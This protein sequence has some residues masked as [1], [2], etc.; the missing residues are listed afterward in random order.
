MFLTYSLNFDLCR[1][2]SLQKAYPIQT[3][4]QCIQAPTINQY[5][6]DQ[7]HQSVKSLMDL[8]VFNE[9]AKYAPSPYKQVDIMKR[10]DDLYAKTAD[11]NISAFDYYSNLSQIFLDLKDPHTM[12]YKPKF[13]SHFS[14]I[15]PFQ[16]VYEKNQWFAHYFHND[17]QFYQNQILY[18]DLFGSLNLNQLDRITKIN[19][20][21]PLDFLTSFADLNS[22]SSKTSHSRLNFEL[23]GNLYQ[24]RLDLYNI[25]QT[26]KLCIEFLSGTKL[27]F[28]FL[29]K[30]EIVVKNS[31]EAVK[32]FNMEIRTEQDGEK[33]DSAE[34][35]LVKDY[36]TAQQ[37]TEDPDFKLII[38]SNG[39][40]KMYNYGNRT[41]LAVN[42][43]NPPNYMN[44]LKDLLKLMQ[45]LKQTEINRLYISVMSNPGGVI[46]LGHVLFSGLFS[47]S[48]PFYGRYSIRKTPIA[49]LLAKARA[50][51]FNHHRSKYITGEQIAD[52]YNTT[53]EQNYTDYYSF[54][55]DNSADVL[56]I[57][58]QIY[59]TRL[60]L[61]PNKVVLFTD[62]KCASTC[63]CFSK[64]ILELDLAYS[65]FVG[66]SRSNDQFDVSS[67]AGGQVQ[68][69]NGFE[70]TVKSLNKSLLTEKEYQ[71]LKAIFI[72]HGGL[73]RFAMQQ[74]YSYDITKPVKTLEYT[75]VET[76]KQIKIYPEV[77]NWQSSVTFRKIIDQI[78]LNFSENQWYGE[79][80]KR[81]NHQ[82]YRT[83]ENGCE[84]FGCEFGFYQ[85]ETGHCI[86]RKDQYLSEA[87]LPQGTVV[88]LAIGSV[89]A[90]VLIVFIVLCIVKPELF[91]KKT[92]DE[93][94][95]L[96]E[97]GMVL[98]D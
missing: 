10:L 93:T 75:A 40:F 74:I 81:D 45:K 55:G 73:Q 62:G 25:P 3:A 41:V 35:L 47:E 19:N 97:E 76:K 57:T 1:M 58:K 26:Q 90:L 17:S 54:D 11:Q 18:E 21:D 23:G 82:I 4:L 88:F 66:G 72:P 5:L 91:K 30:T 70:S 52:W 39:F 48:Y 28:Q 12:H 9:K 63:A 43:F 24:K 80:C 71:E 50:S 64:H 85:N 31:A 14:L 2:N 13:F 65:Y 16:F 53:F 22:Y 56:H 44:A 49:S 34:Q 51:I 15:F 83:F 6:L 37:N 96:V 46:N 86:Q 77:M 60:N 94:D 33:Q 7:T 38:E 79:V 29:V 84:L 32:M 95:Q 92:T 8:H 89:V 36:G 67:Y 42:S 20:A 69:S 87:G 27:Y 98:T 59:N 78:E 68:D 61:Q